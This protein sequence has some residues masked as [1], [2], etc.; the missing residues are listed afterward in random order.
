LVGVRFV[1]IGIN[2]VGCTAEI[3]RN[4][5]GSLRRG[6]GREVL[7]LRDEGQIKDNVTYYVMGGL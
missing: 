3:L 5:A 2:I 4:A 7:K 1:S 6:D